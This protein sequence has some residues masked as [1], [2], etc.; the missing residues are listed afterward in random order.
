ML[1]PLTA[2][3][4]DTAT[5][6]G[7]VD[8]DVHPYLQ[9][10]AVLGKYLPR[11]WRRHLELFGSRSVRAGY[12][13][14]SSP[15]AARLDSFPPSG[16]PPGADL[17]FMRQ[18]LLDE[19][20]IDVGVLNPLLHLG[21]PEPNVE[22]GSALMRAIN[23]WQMAE[24]LE[25]E[26]RLRGSILVPLEWREAALAEIERL[27][28]DRR[29]VQVLLFSRTGTQPLGRRH[30]WHIYEAASDR[31]LPIAIH[32]GDG[33]AF[34]GTGAGW[35]SYYIEMHVSHASAMQ[36]QLLSFLLEGTFERFPGLRLV[37]VEGGWA[38]L[39]AFMWRVDRLWERLREEV[40]HVRR[41]P[42]EVVRERVWFTT[43]P[44]EEPRE[45]RHFLQLLD[46]L[47][48]DDRILFATD[49]PH[50][51]FDAPDQAFPVKLGPELRRRLLSTN[52]R[53]LYRL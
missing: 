16:L 13:V 46:Q 53:Q 18:Q 36:G 31:G 22:F 45:K 20:S 23:D 49:Y 9:S 50:W 24:W 12:Y 42:S 44:M 6:H 15:H 29:F 21:D 32:V 48:M 47:A 10:D 41:P 27:A 7:L 40:P 39:P 37:M 28:D 52:A 38:W 14:T 43:Q 26:P 5:G 11:R 35:P 2:V 51:D 3:E 33:V 34:V 4:R 1:E 25:P 8:C 17:D 30:Y 19:W